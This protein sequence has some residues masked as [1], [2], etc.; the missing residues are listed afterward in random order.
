MLIP[1]RP[2]GCTVVTVVNQ[3]LPLLHDSVWHDGKHYAVS[4][5]TRA[6]VSDGAALRSDGRRAVE[7]DQE[8][9]DGQVPTATPPAQAAGTAEA[10][11]DPTVPGAAAAAAPPS[12]A[13]A[14]ATADLGDENRPEGPAA[15]AVDDEVDGRVERHQHVGGLR[16]V[17]PDQF[18]RHSLDDGL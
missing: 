2:T 9:V 7:T 16:Y 8:G 17:T 10:G 5:R 6:V 15:H 14:E 11:D 1:V 3:R 4:Q 18:E 12:A 13:T